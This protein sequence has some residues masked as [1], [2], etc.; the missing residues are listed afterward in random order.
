MINN[1]D[2]YNKRIITATVIST[3][4][5]VAWIKFYGNRTLKR[6]IKQEKKQIEQNIYNEKQKEILENK[7]IVI[8]ESELKEDDY[9][10]IN[11]KF[12]LID[13]EKLSGSI[14]LRG[15]IF[16][17][18]VLKD[19][20]KEIDSDEKIQLLSN[21]D[22]NEEYFVNF[23]WNS[24]NKNLDLPGK[25]TLWETSSEKLTVNNPVI[26]TYNSKSGLVFKIIISVD[27]NYMFTFRQ[28]VL[29][30]TESEIS[31]NISNEIVRN[32]NIM[33]EVSAGVHTGFIGSFNNTIEEIQ[34]K[35]LEKK[36]YNFSKKFSWAGFTS[37]Y[38]LV[39]LA[40][41]ENNNNINF[42]VKT[43]YND[44][45]YEIY[46]LTKDF[47]LLPHQEK[48]TISLLFTG[49]KILKLLDDYAFQYDLSL[50]DRS[51]DFGWFYFLTKPIYILLKIFYNFLGN[52]GIA[53]LFLT[54]VVK[55]IMF[56]F[57]KK[58]YVSMAK[59]KKIQPKIDIIKNRYSND[60][61]TMNKEL[62]EL[63]KKE[64]V[65]PLSGC[66][67]MLVQ[68]PVFFSLY[69]VL[70]ISIDMR[71]APFFGYIKNLSAKDPTTIWNLFGLLPYN[72]NFFHIG[73]LPCL[74]SLTMW[75]Q[76]KMSSGSS[77]NSNTN[78][79][80]QMA[81]RMMPILFLFMFASMPSGL[82]I[83]WTFSNILTIGQQ[84]YVEKKLI[85]K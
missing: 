43:D 32:K 59:I 84:Y 82:L 75:I 85:K 17:N 73:L 27:D 55:L 57:T 25:N 62:I 8:E 53:I 37:K 20:K 34:Y 45:N 26:L 19:Y 76:Q 52:F 10:N 28:S 65:S 71:Q 4:L 14:N 64:N 7:K 21:N 83:Y 78:N 24:D 15:L 23:G 38:W 5:M 63:Y 54:F 41:D 69:K 79:E 74:M 29:N 3:I 60:K 13:T 80:T 58:S 40:N 77:S 46:F 30:N 68:I 11:D 51:V 61:I 22:K 70:V 1:N 36:D 39:S 81:T 56:P 72:V 2:N 50:F 49:P 18:L 42:N 12:L 66:L 6:E 44:K 47:S 16:D 67:P 9:K 48:E 31:L 35:K 33:E